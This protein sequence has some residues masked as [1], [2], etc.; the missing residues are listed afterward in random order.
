MVNK[1]NRE[2]SEQKLFNAK[3]LYVNK[4]MQNKALP[5]NKLKA[6]VEALDSAKNLR[7]A[8]LLYKSLTESLSRSTTAL[9]EN[10]NRTAGNSSRSTRPSGMI[11]ESVEVD[12]WAILA[13]IGNDK[14]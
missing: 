1:L 8:N 4:L 6:V 5:Q 2:L 11:K 14:A 13:G 12:R 9:T 3:L 7:E 10:A